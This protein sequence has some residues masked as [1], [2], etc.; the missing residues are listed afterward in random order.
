MVNRIRRTGI[1]VGFAL[2]GVG[3]CTT[4]PPPGGFPP[5]RPQFIPPPPLDSLPPPIK[6]AD[7]FKGK[8]VVLNYVVSEEDATAVLHSPTI[9]KLGA[10]DFFVG[11]VVAGDG[12]VDSQ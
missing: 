7:E 6:V 2:L 3:G 11:E 9:K 4:D 5:P 10:R 8:F 1:L 12:R